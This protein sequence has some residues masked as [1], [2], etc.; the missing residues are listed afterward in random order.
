MA[1]KHFVIRSDMPQVLTYCVS[2]LQKLAVEKPQQKWSVKIEEA[3]RARS[4]GS[5]NFY[6]GF[7][8]TP[9]A[10]ALGYSENEMHDELLGS[11]FGW[12]QKEFRGHV[13]DVPR[14]TTTT[15]ENGE[16][17]VLTGERMRL[18]MAHCQK[19]AAEMGVCLP[20]LTGT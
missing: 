12:V 17:D 20:D 13:R 3:K 8:V 15:N 4:L 6:W 2:F 14:R 7:V 9:M 18:Y 1:A 11:Y 19:I 10:E 5:N 16:R